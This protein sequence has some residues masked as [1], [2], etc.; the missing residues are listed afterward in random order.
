MF[1]GN[2]KHSLLLNFI[3]IIYIVSEVHELL[4]NSW[5]SD[6]IKGK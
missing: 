2:L 1:E 4:S 3:L 5:T 6:S